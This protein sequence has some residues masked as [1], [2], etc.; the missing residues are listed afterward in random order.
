MRFG[1]LGPVAAWTDDATP[2]RVPDRKVRALLADLLLHAGRPVATTTLIDDLWGEELPANPTATLQTRLSQLRRALDDAEPGAR[3]L[4]QTRPPGYLLAVAAEAVDVGRFRALA[5]RARQTGNPLMRAATLADALGQW[6]GPAYADVAEKAFVRAAVDRLDEERLAVQEAYAE[7][8]LDIGEHDELVAELTELVARHPL[9][10]RL[11]A[12]HLRALYRA[13]RQADALNSFAELRHRLRDEFGLDP[14]AELAALHK[15]ILDQ[16]PALA[17]ASPPA[18]R[19]NLP[20]ALTTLIGRAA[21][22]DDV[23]DQLGDSRLVTLTGAGGVGKTSLA[24][25]VAR[26]RADTHAD[27]AWLVELAAL[28][29]AAAGP[30]NVAAAVARAL[31]EGG[32]AD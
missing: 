18:P 24:L 31:R 3:N 28:D 12:V 26:R 13:G 10:Q 16:D 11:R 5:A 29:G 25:A 1:V 4:V 9:R 6:R 15:A 20:A 7:V 27:G 2:V 8:R 23:V 30:P 32:G 21:A 17:P 19:T 14:S 22:I